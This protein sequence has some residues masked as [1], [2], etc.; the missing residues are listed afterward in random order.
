MDLNTFWFLI[1]TAILAVYVILDGFD[2]GIGILHIFARNEEKQKALLSMVGPHWDG[3]EVWLVV[4]GGVVFAVFPKIYAAISS[5]FYLPIIVLLIALIF[6]G[7]AVSMQYISSSRPWQKFWGICFGAASLIIVVLFAL[8]LGN[9]ATGVPINKDGI[10]RSGFAQSL[11]LKAGWA[12]VAGALLITMH[13]AVYAV[14]KSPMQL[15]D[16]IIK[17]AFGTWLLTVLCAAPAVIL[18][19][20]NYRVDADN[21]HPVLFA[22]F[23]FLIFASMAAVPWLL[24]RGKYLSAF[25][26]SSLLIASLLGF[27][28]VQLF[29]R[30][31]VS[32]VNDS[33][34]LTIYNA[35]ATATPVKIMLIIV[36]I[37]I[38]AVIA[39][40]AYAYWVL[41]HKIKEIDGY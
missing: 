16:N 11:N 17:W 7:I 32:S 36:G 3:N 25:I 33:Y 1:V 39:Y 31:I 8:V 27:F 6:R 30:I 28:A 24:R 35:S 23:T 37:G 38:P 21:S 10:F 20:Y 15:R 4:L 40:S 41:E 5:G 13:G 22:C 29:P 34:S 9:S 2:L 14:I 12:A 18:K 26:A 19:I